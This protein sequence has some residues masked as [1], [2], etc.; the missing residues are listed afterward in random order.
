MTPGE[1]YEMSEP[2]GWPPEFVIAMSRNEWRRPELLPDQFL[3][4]G[5]C[6]RRDCGGTDRIMPT[7]P[8]PDQPIPVPE[9]DVVRPPTPSEEPEPNEGPG[10]RPSRARTSSF[11]RVLR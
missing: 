4:A 8:Q 9:P 6:F 7:T 11:L 1:R 3:L 10:L 2:P 5:V